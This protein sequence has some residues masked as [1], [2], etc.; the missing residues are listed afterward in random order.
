MQ[1]YDITV[2]EGRLRVNLQATFTGNGIN[3]LLTGGES[4]HIGAVVVC[5]PSST[6]KESPVL[7][8]EVITVPTHREADVA[9]PM[10]EVV[11][12]VTRQVTVVAAGIHIDQ[13]QGWEIVALSENCN[14]AGRKLCEQLEQIDM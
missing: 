3:I 1:S 13:A 5:M 14:L 11:C 7:K 2:G 9:R 10:A 12:G 6:D 8:S 4:P